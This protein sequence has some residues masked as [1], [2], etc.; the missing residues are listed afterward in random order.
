[1]HNL[2]RVLAYLAA[3]PDL[4]VVAP[5]IGLVA[6]DAEKAPLCVVRLE[7]IIGQVRRGLVI[8][9]IPGEE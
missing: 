6:V 5:P 8:C 1:M 4:V 3:D 2:L 9:P 7:Y